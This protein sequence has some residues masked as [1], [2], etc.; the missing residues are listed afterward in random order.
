MT[1]KRRTSEFWGLW[2][3]IN[4][5]TCNA[6]PESTQF[7]AETN[8]WLM[9]CLYQLSVVSAKCRVLN[10]NPPKTPRARSGTHKDLERNKFTSIRST[11]REV[12]IC[13]CSAWFNPSSFMFRLKVKKTKKVMDCG[14]R[15]PQPVVI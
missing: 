12:E 4:V 9:T 3:W 13:S 15:V 14:V 10:T 11:S 7:D 6:K 5:P 1:V 8:A 2:N